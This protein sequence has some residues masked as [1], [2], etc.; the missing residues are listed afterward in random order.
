MPIAYV[1]GDTTYFRFSGLN[2][3]STFKGNVVN[4]GQFTFKIAYLEIFRRAVSRK[5]RKP[6]LPYRNYFILVDDKIYNLAV[7]VMNER[8]ARARRVS[9]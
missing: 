9:H 1:F 7:A 4:F 3:S 8:P 6:A 2:Y 5:E